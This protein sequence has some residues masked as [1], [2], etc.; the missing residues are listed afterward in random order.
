ML[1]ALFLL[2]ATAGCGD[3]ILL[4]TSYSAKD[5]AGGGFGNGTGGGG[6]GYE[7]APQWPVKI[8][9]S[10]FAAKNSQQE[11]PII[12]ITT[13][14]LTPPQGSACTV[15]TPPS[16]SLTCAFELTMSGPGPC[17]VQ[18]DADTD[19]GKV[20]QCFSYVLTPSDQFASASSTANTLCGF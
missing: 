13:L 14:A 7:T 12:S 5:T 1:A 10:V 3:D 15:G 20:S 2:G 11:T 17:V 4:Q 19:K 8:P 6:Q 18:M 16:C 9:V